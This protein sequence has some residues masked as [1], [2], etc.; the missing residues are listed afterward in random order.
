MIVQELLMRYGF[1][2]NTSS[3]DNFNDSMTDSR[4]R[5]DTAAT[6]MNTFADR[7]R[8]AGEKLGKIGKGLS[9]Y[10]TAPLLA[11]GGIAI[12]AAMTIDGATDKIRT[13]TGATGDA[14]MKLKDDFKEVFGQVPDDADKVGAAIADLTKRT[15]LTG[16]PLQALSKDMLDL[17]RVSEGDL[18]AQLRDAPRLMANWNI[19]FTQ[20]SDVLNTLWKTSQVTG[21]KVGDLLTKVTQFGGPMREFGFS[22]QETAA[23]IGQFEKAGINGDMAMAGLRKAVVAFTKD[24]IPLKKGLDATIKQIQ[25]LGPGAKATALGMEVFGNKAGPEMAR[26][27]LKGTLSIDELVKKIGES[28]ETIGKAADDIADFPEK[29]A[30]FKNQMT[31]ALEPLGITLLGLIDDAIPYIQKMVDFIGRM[32]VAFDKLSPGAKV[33][34]VAVAGIVAAIGPALIIIASLIESFLVIAPILGGITLA[35]VGLVAGIAAVIAIF[36]AV[37]FVIQD[38]Y[39]FLTGGQSYFSAFWESWVA[40]I[41]LMRQGFFDMLSAIAFLIVNAVSFWTNAFMNWVTS[42]GNILAFLPRMMGTILGTLYAAVTMGLSQLYNSFTSTFQNVYNSV[43]GW[44]NMIIQKIASI[45]GVGAIV[46]GIGQLAGM[47]PGMGGMAPAVAGGGPLAAY[48]PGADMPGRAA[49]GGS[50]SNTNSFKVDQITVQVPAG[51]DGASIGKAA[52]AGAGKAFDAGAVFRNAQTGA[53][54]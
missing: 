33:A 41:D 13:E 16:V 43:A 4:E 30:Q 5:A 50:T 24:G 10:V 35:G 19:P 54:R 9:T 38:L 18:T 53:K 45:P 14:L 26:M 22:F 48:T 29:F 42:V 27:I 25:K 31:K 51:S 17:A 6:S 40:Y 21:A 11:L 34:I 44:I 37:I 36:L 39:T 15:G 12:G 28:P 47:I 3:I 23:L 1:Q 7:A 8:A 49:A 20:G 32:A 2:G 52:A 46:G